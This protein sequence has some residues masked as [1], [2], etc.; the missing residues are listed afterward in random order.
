MRHLVHSKNPNVHIIVVPEEREK[1][2][3]DSVFEEI[4]HIEVFQIIEYFK[5][6]PQTEEYP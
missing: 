4:L 2:K 5:M 1:N 3:T 6:K